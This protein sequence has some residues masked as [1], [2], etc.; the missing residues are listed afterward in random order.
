MLAAI[1]RAVQEKITRTVQEAFGVSLVSPVLNTPP[2]IDLGDISTPVCFELAKTLQQ[3]PRKIAE[4]LAEKVLPLD[5]VAEARVAGAGYLNFFLDR[6]HAAALGYRYRTQ[7]A[8]EVGAERPGEKI[9]VEHTSINPNKAAH[10]GHLRN[11]LM[12]DAL[13]RLLRD[14]GRRVE[15]QNYI[16]DTGVQVADVVVG[17]T[18]LENKSLEEVAQM[19]QDAATRFDYD[20]WD[21][22]ARVSRFYEEDKNRLR[23]RS[24]T[25]KTIEEGEGDPARMGRIISDAILQKH[26]ETMQ[27]LDIQYDLLAQESEI[28]RLDF[29][30]TAF[31]LLKKSGALTLEDSGKNKGCWVMALNEGDEK[32]S[33]EESA[34]DDAE[35]TE[36]VKI[37]VRSNGTVTYVGKDIAYHLWKFGLL[38]RDFTYERAY[39][40]PTGHEV[41]KTSPN[42]RRQ[43]PPFG[44]GSEVY[45]VIDRRQSYLQNV[46]AAGLRA[47]GYTRQVENLHHVAYEIVGLSQRCAREM[48]IE[49]DEEQK[50]RSYVEVSG[51]KGLGVK[52]DDLIDRLIA[53]ALREVKARHTELPA[54]EQGQIAEV[55]G[56]AALRYF[57]LKYTRNSLIAFDFHGALAFEGETGP[58]LQY[59]VVRA[60]NILRKFSEAHPDF[61][62]D[63]LGERADRDLL[64]RFLDGREGD[65]LWEVIALSLQVELVAEQ[66]VK[67]LEPSVFAKFG[68]KL[69]QAFNNFYHRYHVLTEKDEERQLFLLFVVQLVSTSLAKVLD[70]LGIR[71]PEKM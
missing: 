17:F 35:R 33:S 32:S 46:V 39:R 1:H 22:Y 2:R 52:A 31:E 21:L 62:L 71:V 4:Q 27:R 53:E 18:H 6:A 38:G 16:D 12:G 9:I 25:L 3:P 14:L 42:T 59:T 11:A 48:E 7:P 28:L 66:A 44:A 29:W 60:R 56:I 40:Y 49:L 54:A 5:G 15:V 20:C 13:V 36:D 58:Y 63:T 19:A 10:I 23:L 61:P 50:K 65:P 45:T 64:S 47:M 43:V 69:A 30:K 57:L 68:F 8:V 34:A 41:W 26:L 70:L 67:S 24:E 51:R 55:I 37:I